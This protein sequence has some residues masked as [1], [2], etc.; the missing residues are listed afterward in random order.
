MG[1]GLKYDC[2]VC[3]RGVRLDWLR[4][5]WSWAPWARVIESHG[6]A[7]IRETGRLYPDALKI[8]DFDA[9]RVLTSTLYRVVEALISKGVLDDALAFLIRATEAAKNAFGSFPIPRASSA[10]PVVASGR[11][12]RISFYEGSLDECSKARGQSGRTSYSEVS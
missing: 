7:S 12:G 6:H 2:P 8:R 1:F 5:H 10:P 3:G 9:F 4:R 11:A